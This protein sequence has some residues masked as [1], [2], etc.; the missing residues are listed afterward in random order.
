MDDKIISFCIP[1]Y[2]RPD[3][4]LFSISSIIAQA[5]N[6]QHEIVISEQFR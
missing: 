1:T 6:S 2:N 4:L 5:N 3:K